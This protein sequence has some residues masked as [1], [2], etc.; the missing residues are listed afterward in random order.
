MKREHKKRS[1]GPLIIIFI[2]LSL[3]I[4]FLF[5]DSYAYSSS[6]IIRGGSGPAAISVSIQDYE[7]YIDGF[8][9]LDK[10]LGPNPCNNPLKDPR[11]F[12]GYKINGICISSWA[13][14]TNQAKS[15]T[16]YIVIEDNDTLKSKSVFIVDSRQKPIWRGGKVAGDVSQG[17]IVE[18]LI[19]LEAES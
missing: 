18:A 8:V 19:I 17:E 16:A 7:I 1:Y 15:Y 4:G 12:Q 5:I 3:L 13:D 14:D 10:Y 2:S 9:I 11:L 6:I